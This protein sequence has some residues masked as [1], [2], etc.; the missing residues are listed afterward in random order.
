LLQNLL[1][2]LPAPGLYGLVS[3]LTGGKKSRW[4]MGMLMYSTIFTVLYLIY[5]INKKLSNEDRLE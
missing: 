5:G 3:E 1:G 4:A 2:F